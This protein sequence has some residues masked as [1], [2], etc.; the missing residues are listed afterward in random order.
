MKNILLISINAIGDTYLSLSSVPIIRENCNNCLITL[1]CKPDSI[2]LSNLCQIDDILVFENNFVEC[3]RKL[4]SVK[5]D[6]VYSFFPGRMN[7]LFFL[8]SKGMK[9]TG[10]V[11]FRKNIDW[12]TNSQKITYLPPQEVT[13]YWY[14]TERYLD[15]VA[16]ILNKPVYKT[17]FKLKDQDI[18]VMGSIIIH[19]FSKDIRRSFSEEQI[20]AIANLYYD[21]QVFVHGSKEETEKLNSKLPSNVKIML[22]NENISEF[23]FLLKMNIF[24]STDSFPLHL[25]DSDNTRFLGVFTHTNPKSVLENFEKSVVFDESSFLKVGS[26]NFTE[27]LKTKLV[28]LGYLGVE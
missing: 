8:L 22:I 7:T 28:A 1:L 19:P 24:I 12:H 27:K 5:Y 18:S 11:N 26:V 3:L 2:F 14:P 25:A 16:L 20:I 23:I 4:R 10:Y 15:R 17:K 6:E 9:K 21:K 13:K